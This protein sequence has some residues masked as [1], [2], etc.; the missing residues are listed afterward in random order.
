MSDTETLALL[1]PQDPSDAEGRLTGGFYSSRRC[2]PDSELSGPW[3]DLYPVDTDPSLV[4]SHV[5]VFNEASHFN[6]VQR[7]VV[8][9]VGGGEFEDLVAQGQV[10]FGFAPVAARY[11][12]S[13]DARQD[14][15]EPQKVADEDTRF[16]LGYLLDECFIYDARWARGGA[17]RVTRMTWKWWEPTARRHEP[18][19][20]SP[21]SNDLERTAARDK[22]QRD[23][24][25]LI[26]SNPA[27]AA[28][29]EARST[30]LAMFLDQFVAMADGTDSG[31]DKTKAHVS[32]L[33]LV[34]KV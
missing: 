3:A 29:H 20:D 10:G 9:P 22:Q 6:G 7:W 14:N 15:G 13:I 8:A 12:G 11:K 21:G 17:G 23:R 2:R 25:A 26:D 24:K 19:E 1:T 27:D 18:A 32:D 31:R 16:N 34:F 30:T 33:G 5:L 4:V 28:A